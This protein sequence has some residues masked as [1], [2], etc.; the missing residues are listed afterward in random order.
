MSVTDPYDRIIG[1]LYWSC[2][3]TTQYF[4]LQGFFRLTE[5]KNLQGIISS[6]YRTCLTCGIKCLAK[7]WASVMGKWIV[8]MNFTHNECHVLWLLTIQCITEMSQY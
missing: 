6:E 2:F 4:I 1:F 3:H 5:H 7:S 8:M